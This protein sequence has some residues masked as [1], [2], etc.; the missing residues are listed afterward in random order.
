MRRLSVKFR[1]VSGMVGLTVSIVILAM[2][3]NIIPDRIGA[4]RDG[5]ISLAESIAVHCTALVMGGE[6]PR[7]EN[8]LN[9]LAERNPDLL[10]F[11]LR[12]LDGRM[13]VTAGD[14][15]NHWKPLV[16]EYSTENQILVPISDG[17]KRWGQLELRFTPMREEGLMGVLQAPAVKIGL[18]I[19]LACFLAFYFYLGRVLRQL[20]PSQAI[21]GRVRAALDTMAEGLLVLDRKEQ[22]VLANK[23]FATL[24]DKSPDSLL[25][26]RAGEFPWTDTE[27][28][29]IEKKNR[30]WIQA[31]STGELVANQMMRLQ[32]SEHDRRTFNV[33]CSPVLGGAGKYA[34]VLVSFDDVTQLEQKEIEL[35]I[36]KEEAERANEAKSVFLAS[37]SHEIRTPMNAILGFTEILKR[38][39]ARS[40]EETLRHL[41]TIH[42]SGKSLLALIND[43]LD[44]SKVESGRIEMEKT[45]SEPHRIIHEVLQILKVQA[46]EKG[47]YLRFEAKTALP[48]KIETDPARFRQIVFNLVGN[49]LKFTEQGG[50][51]VAVHF[52]EKGAE[53]RLVVD[54]VDTGIGIPADKV[55]SIFD[56]FTQADSS[57]TRRFGGTG[58]GLSISRRFARLLG[59]DIQV[60]SKLGKG[61]TFRVLLAAGDTTGIHLLQPE[62]TA[63]PLEKMSDKD[64]GMWQFTKA[65][66]LV[67]EDGVETRELIRLLLERAGLD[68]EEA[69]N[70]AEGVKKAAAKSYDVVLM[71]VNMPVMDG[72]T[73][74]T[75]M[76][77]KG[78]NAPIVAL[79]AN[80]MKGF[81]QECLDAGYS[82]YLTKPI[83]FDPFMNLMADLGGGQQVK[84]P[85]GTVSGLSPF[86]K[87]GTAQK[88]Q[89]DEPIPIVSKL[90]SDNEAFAKII[91]RFASQ[92][93]EKLQS[94]QQA[95]SSGNVEEIAAFAH[96]LKGAGGTVGFD[97]FTKPARRL[98]QL[99]REGGKE[100]EIAEALAAIRSLAGRVK[101]PGM[102]GGIPSVEGSKA[103]V[104]P[105]PDQRFSS[106]TPPSAAIKPL[107]SRFSDQPEF[108]RIIHTFLRS[109]EE[110]VEKMEEAYEQ[111]DWTSLASLAHWLKGSGGTVGFDEFTKP[112][113]ALENFVQA[114]QR[115]QA[116]KMLNRIK[117][118]KNAILPP[119]IEG[120]PKKDA[121]PRRTPHLSGGA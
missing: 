106:G 20:D 111:Q 34:G 88:K 103:S 62:E 53:P 4:V 27:G 120:M 74:A 94:V 117:Q 87:N 10:S 70:G 121:A 19:G 42:S 78:L 22:V 15:E 45:Y 84:E 55:Q 35:R 38:G 69:E 17:E 99:A 95:R 76:R 96:W 77:Q 52:N 63:M 23:A 97:E 107:V 119:P 112:A 54:V 25:G 110:N 12:R 61:S 118:L 43:I 90:P 49:A 30:P 21:P 18:F 24:I 40:K 92:L 108:E 36:S 105:S 104:K 59:G 68:V 65:R 113:L 11:A 32:L 101:V 44:L 39:Y 83:E 91:V 56:P 14:H 33:S 73:A 2:Y 6:T 80:A 100:S 47:L 28:K 48:E 31:M 26:H 50:V 7:L 72:F 85:S 79:T 109:L 81:E 102:K 60:A 13:L 86:Q 115:D 93:G 89:D 16:G 98:E 75:K 41:N 51:T 46:D 5:R 67:V 58:L 71:D 9:L 8:D 57:V 116:G 66:V 114:R 3:L 82:H 37:M 29:N 64:T 1:V